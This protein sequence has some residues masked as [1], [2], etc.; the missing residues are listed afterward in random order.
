[1][2]GATTAEIGSPPIAA[3]EP[4]AREVQITLAR[5]GCPT[6]RQSSRPTWHCSRERRSLKPAVA[7]VGTHGA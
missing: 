2:V 4:V 7:G 5:E 3:S 1:M 6:Q